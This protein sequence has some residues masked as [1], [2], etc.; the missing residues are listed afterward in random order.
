MKFLERM[1]GMGDLLS[2]LSAVKIE[3]V[4][5]LIQL[6]RTIGDDGAELRVRV[7]AVIDAGSV[8]VEY[9]ETETDDKLIEFVQNIAKEDGLWQL[10]AIVQDLLDGSPAPMAAMQ[11]EGLALSK[12][13][14]SVPWP[15]VIQLAQVIVMVIQS[16]KKKA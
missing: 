6:V 12:D 8:L 11:G 9:T 14:G 16:L 15:L 13:S 3:D 7:L 1:K 4:T 2:I 5:K 10:V